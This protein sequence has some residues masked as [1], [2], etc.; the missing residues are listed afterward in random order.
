MAE[1]NIHIKTDYTKHESRNMIEQTQEEQEKL[2]EAPDLCG[3]DSL[4]QSERTETSATQWRRCIN[5]K[6]FPL[7]KNTHKC[8]CGT[9]KM[10]QQYVLYF[11]YVL[12]QNCVKCVWTLTSLQLQNSAQPLL[13]VATLVAFGRSLIQVKFK[14]TNFMEDFRFTLKIAALDMNSPAP[15]PFPTPFSWSPL[16]FTVFEM[17]PTV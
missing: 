2:A 9:Q 17:N 16:N 4:E 1:E 15:F 14:T 10:Q 11:L 8:C 12:L 5:A 3:M 13:D 7:N 6:S